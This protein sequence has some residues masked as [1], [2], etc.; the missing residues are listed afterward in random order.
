MF[1]I[2]A[3]VVIIISAPDLLSDENFRFISVW[4]CS[5][6]VSSE[7]N[8]NLYLWRNACE[9]GDSPGVENCRYYETT[10]PHLQWLLCSEHSRKMW[11]ECKNGDP[12]GP[13]S[14]AFSAT[15][16]PSGQWRFAV[17]AE[18]LNEWLMTL[19]RKE[20]ERKGRKGGRKR[21]RRK[22]GK[23]GGR[24]EGRSNKGK[25]HLLS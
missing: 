9:T 2:V 3:V 16:S 10:H 14:S 21:A 1:V 25:N 4:F 6:L 17:L 7:E 12:G 20:G 5:A 13:A 8:Q 22:E 24:R 18:Y 11:E 23:R 15:E 19:R